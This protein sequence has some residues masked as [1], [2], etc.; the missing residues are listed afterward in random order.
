MEMGL[1]ERDRVVSADGDEPS[2]GHDIAK[3]TT[4]LLL[5]QTGIAA[6]V[7][8]VGEPPSFRTRLT[9][10]SN[11][12]RARNHL[13]GMF[14]VRTFCEWNPARDE[15]ALCVGEARMGCHEPAAVS[16]GRHDEWYLCQRC[17]RL[18]FFAHFHER[19]MLAARSY[20]SRQATPDAP[21]ASPPERVRA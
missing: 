4:T 7:H 6:G 19:S 12:A 10:R 14:V 11:G 5:P 17:A 16:L 18:T 13:Q 1:L 21:K 3:I 8:A 2:I 9:D 20:A 15:M